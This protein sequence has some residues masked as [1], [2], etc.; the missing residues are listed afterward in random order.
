MTNVP[1]SPAAALPVLLLTLLLV[2]LSG[3]RAQAGDGDTATLPEIGKWSDQAHLEQE[4][5]ELT[6]TSE[7]IRIDLE[8]LSEPGRSLFVFSLK[9]QQTAKVQQRRHVIGADGQ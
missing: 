8:A 3:P 2:A 5:A 4:L 6:A 9:R 1:R 7:V